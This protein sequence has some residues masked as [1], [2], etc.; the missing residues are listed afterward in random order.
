VFPGASSNPTSGRALAWRRSIVHA[1]AVALLLLAGAG[2]AHAAAATP[3]LS[4]A[5]F[6]SYPTGIG[7]SATAAA[8]LNRDGVPDLVVV[9][10]FEDTISV[11]LG[12]VS[13]PGTYLDDARTEG[14]ETINLT[15]S[16][17][18]AGAVLGGRS[19]AVLTINAD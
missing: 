12:N 9:N 13:A 3:P 15:L 4:F 16:N 5:G 10:N 11:L 17:P 19:T 2:A 8:D 7:A 6:T 1:A 14:A 18:S